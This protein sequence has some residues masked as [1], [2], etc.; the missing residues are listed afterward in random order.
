MSAPQTGFA[1]AVL[2]PD[3]PV[4]SSLAAPTGQPDAKRFAVYRNNVFVSLVGALESR[5]PVTRRLVGDDFFRGMARVYA[6]DNRP[7]SPVMMHYGDSFPAFIAGFA[8]A[9]SVHYLADVAYIEARWSDAYNA[10]DAEPLAVEALA[11]IPPQEL[12]L[13]CLKR[14]P[15]A[16]LI[17]S[18]YPAGSIWSANLGDTP[19]KLTA[20]GPETIIVTRPELEVRVSVL[21]AADAPFVAALLKG[22]SI[23]EAVTETAEGFDFGQALVGL[24]NLGAFAAPVTRGSPS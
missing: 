7:A 4:P 11:T 14:H 23:A 20:T 12:P 15:A 17:R 9:A 1:A 13:L 2:D 22:A 5:F 10:A 18:Q 3:A 24:V 21:P 19:P 8:P 16:A 6:A